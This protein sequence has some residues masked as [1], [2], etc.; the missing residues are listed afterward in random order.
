VIR[1]LRSIAEKLETPPV[2]RWLLGAFVVVALVLTLLPW[3]RFLRGGTGTDYR[4]WFDGGQAIWRQRELYPR[5]GSFAFMYPP[6]CALLVALPAA[7]GKPAFI[8]ILAL[9]NSVAWAFCI[10]L[11]VRI[12]TENFPRL[13]TAIALLP[14]L[15]LLV[16]IWSSY[17]LGQPSLVLLALMLAAFLCLR[18]NRQITAGVLIAVAAAIKAFPLLALLYLVYRRYWLAAISLVVTLALLLLV[19]PLPFRGPS[20]TMR[21]FQSWRR[22]MLRYEEKGIAQ[23]QL[24]GYSWKNQSIFGLANRMLRQVSAD[25]SIPPVYANFANLNWRTVNVIIVAIALLTGLSYVLVM[26]RRR[27]TETDALEFSA[28][29]ILI[30]L[31]TPLAF[32]YL[33][34]WL[35][36]PLAVLINRVFRADDPIAMCGLTIS[37]ALLAITGL[38][39]RAAQIYGSV[40]FAALALYLTF[41]IE[42]WRSRSLELAR[43]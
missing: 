17:H 40:F 22:G 37:L 16:Y 38:A 27:R 35:M 19:L 36:L 6:S 15:I 28:L 9:L 26:P 42:L 2:R 43:S 23:R 24:R 20:Q 1:R 39:P 33:F 4:V 34:V 21:D 31:F 10:Y 3:L 8:F 25:E 29:L 7:L 5:G 12:A 30:L 14:S 41:V 32:G 11:S 18:R 13:R